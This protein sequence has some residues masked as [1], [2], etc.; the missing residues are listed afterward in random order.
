VFNGVEVFTLSD[1]P[2]VTD[3]VEFKVIKRGWVAGQTQPAPKRT[4]Q[5]RQRDVGGLVGSDGFPTT[6]AAG[7]RQCRQSS[8]MICGKRPSFFGVQF[9]ELLVG[10]WWCLPGFFGQ[11]DDLEFALMSFPGEAFIEVGD[12]AHLAAS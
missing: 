3:F 8:Q 6:K 9:S 4:K 1:V 12:V 2:G 5:G 10:H 11:L 7:K